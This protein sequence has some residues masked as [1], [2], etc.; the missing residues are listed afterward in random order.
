MYSMLRKYSDS[1]PERFNQDLLNLKK[2]DNVLNHINAIFSALEVINGVEF[3]GSEIIED[4]S[5]FPD[6]IK[7]ERLIINVNQ[8]RLILIKYKFK[9]SGKDNDGNYQEEVIDKFL[10]FPKLIDGTYFISNGNKFFP[11]YQII[12]SATYNNND[13][14][15][16]KTLLMGV[17]INVKPFAFYDFDNNEYKARI[18]L[19]NLFKNKLNFLLYFFIDR[20]FN[21]TMKYYIGSNWEEHIKLVDDI[22][23]EV[24]FDTSKYIKFKLN[25]KSNTGI[26]ISKALWK[27]DPDFVASVIDILSGKDYIQIMDIDF[28]LLEVGK[29]FSRNKNNYL[30]KAKDILI[31]FKRILDNSTKNTLRLKEKNK[32]DIFA[33]IRWMIKRYD[34]LVER[35]NMDLKYKRIRINEYLCYD[36]LI[37]MSTSTYRLLNKQEITMKDRQQLFSTLGPMFVLKKIN[38]NEL[39]RYFGG[40][41]AIEVFNPGLKF[42]MRG[43]QGLGSSSKDVNKSYRGLH[44]SYIG[45][46]GLVSSS[47]SDPGM[48]GTFTPFMQNSGFYFTDDMID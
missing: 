2:N 45:R 40:V 25:K 1:N 20:G 8:S 36:L 10:F 17:T 41:N 33:I 35:D 34:V 11:I 47:S 48:S 38:T 19:I 39:C 5:S 12:D 27:K 44:P 4:E 24:D 13:S 37:K 16:L 6:Y 26:Y 3:L 23:D 43:F 15:T 30:S 21:D 31:S 22:N 32:K 29:V 7:N 14:L 28:W 42:S 46:L 9:I 18:K